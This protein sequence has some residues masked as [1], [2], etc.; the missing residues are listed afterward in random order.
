[1]IWMDG[2]KE[3]MKVGQ[4]DDRKGRRMDRWKEGRKEVLT[5]DVGGWR[6]GRKESRTD[7]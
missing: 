6:E 3:G 4:T 2:E 5:D 1:M 7:R